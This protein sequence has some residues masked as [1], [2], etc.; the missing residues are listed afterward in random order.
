MTPPDLSSEL[1]RDAEATAESIRASARSEARRLTDEADRQI[2]RK[3]E[4]FLERQETKLRSAARLD[5]AS[6]R[7]EAMRELLLAKTRLVDRV[8]EAAEAG[9]LA[10]SRSEAYLSRLPALTE[11]ALRFAEEGEPLLI[12]CS[13]EL[14]AAMNSA[15]RHRP[16]VQ[17]EADPD[18]Q[19]GFVVTGRSGSLKIDE[20][21]ERALEEART[22]LGIAIHARLEGLAN[23]LLSR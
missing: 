2:Q 5:I 1:R 15:S 6:A 18:I 19:S 7:Q 8:I 4:A 16:G 13:P 22:D 23:E 3:L 12:R 14:V 17:V 10:A 20:R 21:L 9:L 11:E